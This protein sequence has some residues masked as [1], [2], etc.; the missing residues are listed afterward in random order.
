MLAG[1][2]CAQPFDLGPSGGNG[3]QQAHHRQ[4]RSGLSV[5]EVAGVEAGRRLHEV[6]PG[7]D[8]S[9]DATAHLRLGQ[10]VGFQDDL[11][12]RL[13]SVADL[14]DGPQVAL[15]VVV[16]CPPQEAV[17]RNDVDFRDPC[18]HDVARL[19]DPGG[20]A[21]QPEREVDDNTDAGAGARTQRLGE[22]DRRGVN[23][24]GAAP[25]LHSPADLALDLLR[26]EL[27]FEHRVI[28]VGRELGDGQTCCRSAGCH[29][30]F[31]PDQGRERPASCIYI[32]PEPARYRHRASGTQ[33]H[34]R[35]ARPGRPAV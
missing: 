15:D 31:L 9:L 17:G 11:H 19:G 16:A 22:G 14:D 1:P 8:G 21:G 5:L 33:W 13:R 6:G 7:R 28:D 20:R 27:G 18:R 34:S 3:A 12:R 2:D 30:G 23:T 25:Q 35:Y 10:R 29:V 24:D 32:L 26:G 4:G